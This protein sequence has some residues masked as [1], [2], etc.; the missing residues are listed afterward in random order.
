MSVILKVRLY[1]FRKMH[2]EFK[3]IKH[4]TSQKVIVEC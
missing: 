3:L 4:I 1:S 2:L